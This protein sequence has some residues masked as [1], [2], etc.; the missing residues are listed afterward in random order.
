MSGNGSTA[1][2]VGIDLGK[3]SDFTAISILDKIP[4]DDGGSEVHVQYL[5]RLRGVS[6]TAVVEEIAQMAEW[7]A[8]DG[9]PFIVDATGL[10]RPVFDMLAQRVRRVEALTIS[11]GNIVVKHGP[12]EYSVPKADLV[13]AMQVL[14][15]GHRIKV[16]THIPDAV[17]FIQELTD[18]GYET[19]DAGRTS[20]NATGA[21]HDDL[22]LSVAL[23]AWKLQHGGRTGQI[24]MEAFRIRQETLHLDH[25][26]TLRT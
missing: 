21:G 7:P 14:V 24:W 22:V 3:Q 20:F 9:C 6:Y 1:R 19:S 12:R 23:A 11:S 18:F 16:G 17:A 2:V 8:L 13:G 4:T 25:R 5:R 15:A 10:G 26:G